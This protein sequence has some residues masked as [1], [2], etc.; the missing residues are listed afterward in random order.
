[1]RP[2]RPADA[3]LRLLDRLATTGCSRVAV[4]FDKHRTPCGSLPF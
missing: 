2:P 1:M 3:F 4:H